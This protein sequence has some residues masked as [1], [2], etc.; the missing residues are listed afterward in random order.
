MSAWRIFAACLYLGFIA[1]VS[2]A[3]F[4]HPVADD[5]DR[6]IYE[7]LVRGKYETLE[8]VYP[9]VKHSS[10]RAEES[11]VL[12]SPTHL[13]Q[14]EPLYA[15]KPLY[16]KAIEATSFTRLPI[17][18]RISLIS[19]VSLFGIGIVVLGWTGKPGYS[20]LLLATSAIVVVGRM[21]T[22]DG[23]SAFV[24]L[25][26]LWAISRNRLLIGVLLLLVSIWIRT[27]NLLL[28][29]AVLGYLL[30]QKRMTLVDA[31]VISTLSVGSVVLINHFSGN[32]SWRVLF[33]FSFIA[34]RSPAEID[35]RF[36]LAQYLGVAARSAETI[37]PQ[38]AIWALLGIVAWKWS[39]PYRGWL[40][41]V[42]I[43]VVGHFVLY[44][45]PE[46]RYLVWAFIVTGVIFVCAIQRPT[47]VKPQPATIDMS[48]ADGRT[49]V[50]SG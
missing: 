8:V 20:A 10:K 26:G 22:P 48:E 3:C 27:D 21:G 33:Q 37:I 7:A 6:Y 30:W 38:V 42:W 18:G 11:S 12:D 23:L 29:V 4:R 28:V 17:Q 1:G 50:Q 5:F 19:A 14:L 39:S 44:P 36:S 25:A 9:T 35:P 16:V 24:V 49:P 2:W 46:S 43:A 47:G 15:I 31:G 32:Y 41:P 34:G 13:G 45:S 40:I